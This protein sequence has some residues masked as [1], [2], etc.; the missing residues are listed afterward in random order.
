[1]KS[2]DKNNIK[3]VVTDMD[4][5]LLTSEKSISEFSLNIIRKLRE[6]GI[7][8]VV[9]TART[10]TSIERNFPDLEFDAGIFQNGTKIRKGEEIISEIK[11]ED[12]EILVQVIME[13]NPEVKIAIESEGIL[14][15]N[16][17]IEQIWRGANY[18]QTK[19]FREIYGKKA[20]KIVI[21]IQNEKEKENLKKYL[22]QDLQIQDSIDPIIV[23]MN[24]RAGKANGIKIL[25]EHMHIT[26][27]QI[28][29]FG[30]E[31]NDI[32]M[33][34]WCGIGVAMGNAIQSAK[35]ISNEI[36]GKND[37]DGVA[38]WLCYYFN[39]DM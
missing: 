12:P 26:P 21:G 25:A 23:V 20:E 18:V 22:S 15:S 32:D 38:K 33:L 36:C 10:A 8:F 7:L 11:I 27:E 2:I 9:A 3:L 13:K 39:I 35:M 28:V 16:F 19:D 4:G 29:A 37:E 34:E 31:Y 14:F 5:T 1:M 6:R 30:D 24:H 17:D